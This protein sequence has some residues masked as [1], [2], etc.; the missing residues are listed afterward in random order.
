MDSLLSLRCRRNAD[1]HRVRTLSASEPGD[2]RRLSARRAIARASR[3]RSSGAPISASFAR[4]QVLAGRVK[5]IA[6]K[7]KELWR[8]LAI[9]YRR[10]RTLTRATSTFIATVRQLAAASK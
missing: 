2:A 7:E 4:D 6:P 8:E 5:L 1:S 3:G 10:D 9:A